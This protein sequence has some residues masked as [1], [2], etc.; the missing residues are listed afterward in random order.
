MCWK[1]KQSCPCTYILK[2]FLLLLFWWIFVFVCFQDCPVRRTW[3]CLFDVHHSARLKTINNNNSSSR[4]NS[5]SIWLLNL[6]G[7]HASKGKLDFYHYYQHY[8]AASGAHLNKYHFFPKTT[9]WAMWWVEIGTSKYANGVT[10]KQRG[11]IHSYTNIEARK[12]STAN[13]LQCCR[14]KQR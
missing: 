4:N 13:G 1:L 3:D 7:V 8:V 6:K 14:T 2:P 11:S 5:S 9:D 10:E 12:I